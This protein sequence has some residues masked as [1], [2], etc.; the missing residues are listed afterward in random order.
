MSRTRY[1]FGE[2]YRPH[3]LTC[4]VVAWLPV[5]TRPE[6]VQIVLDSWKFLQDEGRMTLL[7]FVVLENHLH[8]VASAANLGKEVGDFKSYTAKRLIE[9]LKQ[10]NART[11]LD[12]LEHFKLRHKVDQQFQLWQEGSQPKEIAD[13]AMLR[14][15]LEYLHDNPVKRGY[16]DD[17]VHWRY[18]S[19]RNYARQPGLVEVCTDW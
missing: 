10:S 3:F 5:F 12:Q 8:F 16:V 1:R 9:L 13:E 11:L 19:A 4:T 17:P 2:G 6:A 14:Q 7:G 15:K 18:S